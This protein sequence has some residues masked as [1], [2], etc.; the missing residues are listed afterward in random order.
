M[1]ACNNGHFW[2]FHMDQVTFK[3][4]PDAKGGHTMLWAQ[5][6]RPDRDTVSH[7]KMQVVER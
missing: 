7:P 1:E 5:L 6:P 2:M 4:R 3:D